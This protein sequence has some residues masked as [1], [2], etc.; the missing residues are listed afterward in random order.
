MPSSSP[1]HQ[2]GGFTLIELLVVIAIIAI[3]VALLL[4][5]VQQAREA[6]RRSSCKNNLKQIVL[7]MH[8]YHDVYKTLPAGYIVSEAGGGN[9]FARP[10]YGWAVAILPFIE[11]GPL[12]DALAPNSPRGLTNVYSS[13]NAADRAL[14]QSSI[15]TFQCPSDVAPNPLPPTVANFGSGAGGHPYDVGKSN[16][17]AVTFGNTA[18][19]GNLAAVPTAA[20][21]QACFTGMTCFKFSDITDGLSNVFLVGERDGGPT[22]A[23][24]DGTTSEFFAGTW[25]GVP[26]ANNFGGTGIHMHLGRIDNAQRLNRDW[27]AESGS[28]TN[29]G[30]AFSSLHAGGAQFG[31]G[32]G[33]VRFISQN[34]SST[35]YQNLA[36][37]SDGNPLGEF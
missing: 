17:L 25:V 7:A 8:N 27:W 18:S 9:R 34:L 37:K 31:M 20:A 4:P 32:D 13:G 36:M 23:F 15:D 35:T 11:Q 22:Q 5:A 10:Q 14:L 30:R 19:I 33:S 1:S 3:L 24:S 2:R 12:Y 6:A 26:R 28:N 21:N 29:G 16:Y